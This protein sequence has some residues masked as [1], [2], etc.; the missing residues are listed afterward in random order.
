MSKENIT[1][2]GRIVEVVEFASRDG[3][4][5]FEKARRAPGT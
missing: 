4:K 5:V 1:Y 3:E 2:Q